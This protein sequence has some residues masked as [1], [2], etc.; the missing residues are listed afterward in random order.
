VKIRL[1]FVQISIKKMLIGIDASRAILP[2]KGGPEWYSYYLIRELLRL[3]NRN[4]YILY[5]NKPITCGL[6][7]IASDR[8]SNVYSAPEFDAKGFQ[9]IKTPHNNAKASILNWPFGFLWSQGRLSLEMLLSRPDL[10]F[11]PSHVLPVVHPKRSVVT[12]H[13]IGFEREQYFSRRDRLGPENYL[14]N[15][16]VDR[17]VRVLTLGR[18]GANTLDYMSWSAK[19]GLEHAALVISP[20]NFTKT[21]LLDVYSPAN[22]NIRVV[23][24]GYNDKL[25]VKTTD[26]EITEQTL[27][28]YGIEPPFAMYV[29]RIERKKNICAL[30]EAFG[31]MRER[32]KDIKEKLLLVGNA[33]FGYDEVQYLIHEYRLDHEVLMPGWVE[34]EDMPVIY[35]SASAFIFPSRYEGFGIPLLQAMGC[36]V[37]V[38]AADSS[39]IP[40]VTGEAA[41]L[42]DP[43]DVFSMAEA[44]EKILA[45]DDARA[46]LRSKGYER[47]KSYSWE[48]CARETLALIEEAGTG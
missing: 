32:R 33:S 15:N 26:P 30:I 24:N 9:K 20:S 44:I 11:I 14:A 37:P 4:E 38:A 5:A 25:F 1:Q 3:D 36:G 35:G 8:I 34:E 17:L 41:L 2:R 43:R 46:D 18:H 48:K 23:R 47:V 39:S 45:D 16:V 12:M 21:E 31:I 42:F 29:G 10:L 27:A 19:Y 28:K 6:V 7:D 13:D 40:E 22:D